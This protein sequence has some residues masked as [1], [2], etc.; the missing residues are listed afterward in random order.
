MNIKF[1]PLLA[2]SAFA[3]MEATAQELTSKIPAHADFVVS[4]NNKA[5]VEQSSMELLNET[6][7]KLGAFE[8]AKNMDFPIKNLKELDFNL[9]KQAYVYRA[10][11]DSLH[12][13]GI[14][15]PLKA[16]HQV[17]QHMFSQY[18]VLPIYNGYERRVS[19]DG[20]T[21]VA[22]NSET[23]FILTG[24][25]HSQYFQ[26]KDVADRYGLDL[27]SYATDTWTYNEALGDAATAA[28]AAAEE[29]V[30]AMEEVNFESEEGNFT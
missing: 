7:T 4:I 8:Q 28:T 12:Y 29:A 3:G 14:L 9:D 17:K 22:W 30:E 20:K 16:N 15:L 27:G 25:V 1:L 2:L 23:M 5:I 6:L 18:E 13:I 19:K 21:Q 24:D 26:M 11:T 10:N